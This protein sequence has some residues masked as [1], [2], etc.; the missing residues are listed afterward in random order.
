MKNLRLY[1]ARLLVAL[2]LTLAAYNASA[3]SG[4]EAGTTWTL[5]VPGFN[6]LNSVTYGN[7]L[8][9][10]VRDSPSGSA[11]YT[12]RNG[13]IWTEQPSPTRKRLWG[14]A[15]GNG[16]FVAVGEDGTILTSRDGVSWTARASGTDNNPFVCYLTPTPRV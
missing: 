13:R 11:I 4:S 14:V 6:H 2:L 16:L 10:A 8:F 7:G 12:S 15:Y 3:S 5:R 9:V 1:G